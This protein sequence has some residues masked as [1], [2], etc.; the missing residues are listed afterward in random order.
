MDAITDFDKRY[1]HISKKFYTVDP[2]TLMSDWTYN[3]MSKRRD[4]EDCLSL[5]AGIGWI[6]PQTKE[7][8]DGEKPLLE[9][10]V[11]IPPG[12]KK[13]IDGDEKGVNSLQVGVVIYNNGLELKPESGIA[14]AIVFLKDEKMEYPY[15]VHSLSLETDLDL[16][17]IEVKALI[18][19]SDDRMVKR[20][21]D[22]GV[23]SFYLSGK[24]TEDV[25]HDVERVT[26]N[27]VVPH[28]DQTV[29]AK[30]FAKVKK[31]FEEKMG[32][33]VDEHTKINI[34]NVI[35]TNPGTTVDG[36]FSEIDK[37]KREL[38]LLKTAKRWDE[39]YKKSVEMHPLPNQKAKDSEPIPAFP[40][41]D[42]E[43]DKMKEAL[44][45]KMKEG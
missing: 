32:K 10:I 13:R 37:A 15:R 9:I 33:I 24:L 27:R 1:S 17:K 20:L 7:V 41:V 35:N 31:D 14:T 3:V 22:D 34:K 44:K 2:L 12:L 43:F 16:E 28:I 18:S 19:T 21:M 23:L 11:G 40:E 8:I 45:E 26:I 39:V 25:F 42:L 36:L 6:Q 5:A 29:Y 30:K 4:I 38:D